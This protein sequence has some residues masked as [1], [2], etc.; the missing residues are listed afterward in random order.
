MDSGTVQLTKVVATPVLPQRPV[1]PASITCADCTAPRT[2]AVH[3][4]V[5]VLRHVEVDDVLH[6][7]EIEALGCD[8]GGNKHVLAATLEGADGL[9]G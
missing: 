5:N 4:V 7:G 6:V 1:R 3:V 8:V 2:D 9:P